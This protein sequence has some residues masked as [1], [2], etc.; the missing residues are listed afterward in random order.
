MDRPGAVHRDGRDLSRD[1]LGSTRS[2]KVWGVV[3]AK[4]PAQ[5]GQRIADEE[6]DGHQ[7]D[8]NADGEGL[9]GMVSPG[10][11]VLEPPD[12]EERD[13]KEAGGEVNA[14]DPPESLAHL[15]EKAT[16][17]KAR[18]EGRQGVEK[19]QGGVEGT[20][21][22]N[23]ELAG[24]REEDDRGTEAEQLGANAQNGTEQLKRSPT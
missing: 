22:V 6:P 20:V 21:T 3:F 15:L 11:C 8:D 24:Q 10:H 18:D 5:N 7:E 17:H 14:L 13:G 19:A 12:A 16:G 23:A 9:S 2:V 4:D 1:V